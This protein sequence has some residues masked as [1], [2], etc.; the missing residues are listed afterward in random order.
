[1]PFLHREQVDPV[2]RARA[3]QAMRVRLRQALLD[4]TLS[5]EQKDRIR[6][7]LATLG[8]PKVYGDNPRTEVT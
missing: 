8:Q 3:E 4:T 6:Q 5:P 1:M 2:A 7:E